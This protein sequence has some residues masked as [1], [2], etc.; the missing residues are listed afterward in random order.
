MILSALPILYNTI[1]SADFLMV[2]DDSNYILE[3]LKLKGKLNYF[4][5]WI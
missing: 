4:N 5:S 2:I 1:F 3:H